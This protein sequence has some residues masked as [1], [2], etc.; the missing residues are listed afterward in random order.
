[1]KHKKVALTKITISQTEQIVNSFD[2]NGKCS[3]LESSL[4]AGCDSKMYYNYLF[5]L[6]N[7]IDGYI[8]NDFDRTD[9]KVL[10][11]KIIDRLNTHTNQKHYYLDEF[12][13]KIKQQIKQHEIL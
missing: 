5:I 7:E 11:E 13:F 8:N 4:K 6:V 12:I 3:I 10:S 1:M 2:I 9:F